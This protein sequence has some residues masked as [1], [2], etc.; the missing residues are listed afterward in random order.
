MGVLDLFR[1]KPA[2]PEAP[3]T[4]PVP[5]EYQ[6]VD[7]LEWREDCPG[8]ATHVFDREGRGVRHGF[9]LVVN[10]KTPMHPFVINWNCEECGADWVTPI[11]I[12]KATWVNGTIYHHADPKFLA[13]LKARAEIAKE[14]AT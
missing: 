3:P 2:E 13:I 5:T 8:C 7:G 12:A 6:T 10:R 14:S 4:P 9:R 11:H 1:R